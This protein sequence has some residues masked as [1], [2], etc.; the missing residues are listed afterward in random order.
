MI[1]LWYVPAS[2]VEATPTWLV[3]RE[4]SVVGV[5]PALNITS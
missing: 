5:E 1:V 4:V 3:T 2:V